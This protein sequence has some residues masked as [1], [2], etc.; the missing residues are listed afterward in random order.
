MCP[1]VGD[2]VD[3]TLTS[4]ANITLRARAASLRTQLLAADAT[5]ANTA[6]EHMIVP[7]A[8]LGIAFMALLGYPAFARILFG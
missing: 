5:E 3:G 7:V 2:D 1:H 8:L 6:S 4:A